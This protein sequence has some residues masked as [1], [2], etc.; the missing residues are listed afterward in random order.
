MSELHVSLC[1]SH[2][3]HVRALRFFAGHRF[4]C[5]RSLDYSHTEGSCDLTRTPG[6]PVPSKILTIAI[7]K[8]G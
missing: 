8:W 3:R 1:L 4:R 7:D 5:S 2:P 6:V